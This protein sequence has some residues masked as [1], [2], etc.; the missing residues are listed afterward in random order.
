SL[1][2]C[3][4][5]KTIKNVVTVNEELTA[6][7]WKRRYERERDKVSRLRAQLD[8]MQAELSRWRG[9]ETVSA[10]EQ[11]NLKEAF[12]EA[13]ATTPG[14]AGDI[15][16]G[17]FPNPATCSTCASSGCFCPVWRRTANI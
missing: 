9:G 7:E 3:H 8:R 13:N 2:L 14:A 17:S 5:A 16:P 10:D 12:Q 15:I 11:V 4:R 1:C 6:E